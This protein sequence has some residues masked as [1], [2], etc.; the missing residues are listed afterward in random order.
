MPETVPAAPYRISSPAA[1]GDYTNKK[2]I[3]YTTQALSND[4][5]ADAIPLFKGWIRIPKS[6]QRFGL[7]DQLNFHVFAQALDQNICGFVTY[8]EYF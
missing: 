1:L 2:N 7:D 5:D 4:Q 8:K 3:L 6:K